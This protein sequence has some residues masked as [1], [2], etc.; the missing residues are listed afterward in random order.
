MMPREEGPIR[1]ANREEAGHLLAPRLVG[2]REDPKAGVLALP[3]GGVPVGATLSRELHLPLDVL[4][5]RKIGS[6][7]NAEYALGAVAE[8]GFVFINEDA[9]RYEIAIGDFLKTYLDREI[10]SQKKEIARRQVL[11]RQGRPLPPLQYQTVLLV[12]DGV[13]TGSTYLASVQA[14]RES[15]VGKIVAGI[16]VGPR[17]TVRRIEQVVDELVV[18]RQPALF[19]AVGI[20]Y[21]DFTP[22]EDEQVCQ[23]LKAAPGAVLHHEESAASA[24]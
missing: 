3:R 14:L 19:E 9:L 6:P 11:Y 4:I 17:E 18:L 5:T 20:H 24:E 13:A 16:P 7:G 12:D 8:T 1:F 10:E 15:Q 23:Y 2:Y 21:E 22:V